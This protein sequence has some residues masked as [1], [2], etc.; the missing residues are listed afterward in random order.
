MKLDFGA[1]LQPYQRLGA[2]V[3]LHIQRL[4]GFAVSLQQLRAWFGQLYVGP[5]ALRTLN[6]R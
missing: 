2:D 6:A 1:L 4:G 5:L 3:D